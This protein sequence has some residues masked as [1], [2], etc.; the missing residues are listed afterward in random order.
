MPIN[1]MRCARDALEAPPQEARDSGTA[2]ADFV[3]ARR[4][5]RPF[6]FRGEVI[7][8]TSEQAGRK[9]G[10]PPSPSEFDYAVTALVPPSEKV[11][12]LSRR[13]R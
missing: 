3:G 13:P 10:P 1:W 9:S 7:L 12:S 8:L 4:F 11:A 2:M 6:P 5:E